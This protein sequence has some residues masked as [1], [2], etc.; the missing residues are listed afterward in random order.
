MDVMADV[1]TGHVAALSN[2]AASAGRRGDPPRA[3]CPRRNPRRVAPSTAVRPGSNFQCSETSPWS[4]GLD[5]THVSGAS[6]QKFLPEILGSG[7]LFFDF[8]D[9]GWL[10]I[11]LVDGGSV[12]DRSRRPT[13]TPSVVQEPRRTARSRT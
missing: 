11:F 9:D 7:G 5:F 1:R 8:D 6:D 13:R 3:Y 12:A 4:A 10:D 2:L